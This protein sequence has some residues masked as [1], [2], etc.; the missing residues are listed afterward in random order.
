MSERFVGRLL[1]TTL[2]GV[3]GIV[4]SADF[5]PVQINFDSGPTAMKGF[6][7]LKDSANY[8]DARGYGFE[9]F[10]SSQFVTYPGNPTHAILTSDRSM[11]F[12]AK[13]PEGNYRVTVWAG[14]AEADTAMAIK[15]ESRRIVTSFVK[16]PRGEVKP[17]EFVVNVRTDKI[18]GGGGVKIS[19]R[20]RAPNVRHWDDKLT[21]EFVG[22][23]P[24]INAIKIEKA[25][26]LTT[27][28]LVGD[29]TVTDQPGEPWAAWG[30]LIPQYFGPK[31][32]VANY[33]ESGRTFRS[34]KGDRRWEKV[35][36]VIKP[37]DSVFMQFGHND[38][39]EKGDGVGPY[40]TFTE[41]I[42][43]FV[44]DTRAKQANPVL[45][46]PMHRRK[47]AGGEIQPTFGDYP[48]AVRKAAAELN[49]PLIDLQAMSKPLFE[50]YGP[51]KSKKLF[52]YAPAG[53]YPGQEKALSD[54]THFNAFGAD[55][56]ARCVVQGIKDLK[57]PLAA[58]LK[59]GIPAFDPTKP[60]DP[61]TFEIPESR[62]PATQKTV[63]PEGR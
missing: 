29:S 13:V 19:D 22:K 27:V 36:S 18:A 2:L 55:L 33:A 9:P 61:A 47:F 7:S 21:L 45:L 31:V 23:H 12:S 28:F 52:V 63:V 20:E 60:V 41:S 16:V 38:M 49:V 50:A 42:R 5:Q 51:E 8:S 58:D 1:I 3:A 44:A 32:A 34:F 30:Q 40:T 35:L 62:P 48:D 6:V 54:D 11:Y 24:A 15:A 46:T 39:K 59:D 26:D 17:V 4:R 57:L 25:D 14:D 10:S 56:I 37:G 43:Q 53:T